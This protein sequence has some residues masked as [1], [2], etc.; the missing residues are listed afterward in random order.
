MILMLCF[1]SANF[2]SVFKIF[3]KECYDEKHPKTVQ[4][5]SQRNTCNSPEH[6]EIQSLTCQAPVLRAEIRI[7]HFT[8]SKQECG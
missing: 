7:E 1:V 8:K 2:V 6:S 5:C 4:V 3:V